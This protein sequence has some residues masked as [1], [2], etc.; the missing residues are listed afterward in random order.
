MNEI[1]FFFCKSIVSI[2]EKN[3]GTETID[4]FRSIYPW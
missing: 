2:I 4:T 1:K 3:I